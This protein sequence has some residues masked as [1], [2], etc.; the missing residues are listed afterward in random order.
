MSPG[1]KLLWLIVIFSLIR[2]A[3][4]LLLEL[5][6]DEAYYWVWSEYLHLSYYDH[7]PMVSYV[8]WLFTLFSDSE[9]FVRMPAIA[10]AAVSSW[11]LYRMTI[12]LYQDEQAGYRAALIANLCLIFAV[13]GFVT[14]PDS[15][16]IPLYLAGLWFFYKAVNEDGG[17]SYRLWGIAGLFI[18]LAMLSKYTAVFFFPGAMVYLLM[19]KD[20][21]K[22]FLRPHLWFAALVAFGCF[23][24]VVVWNSS[25]D[26]VS[27]SFQAGHGLASSGLSVSRLAEFV[28]FQVVVYSVGIFFF[29]VAALWRLVKGCVNLNRAEGFIFAMSAPII[30]FFLVNGLRA[31]M[32]GNWPVLA[33]LPLIIQ[34]AVM[35]PGWKSSDTKRRLW[36]GSIWFAAALLAF[37]HIQ[38]ANPIVPHPQRYEISRRV[39]GWEL[40]ASKLDSAAKGANATFTLNNRHQIAGLMAYYTEGHMESYVL[41]NNRYRYFFLPE[42]ESR[43][44]ENAVYVTEEER[45]MRKSVSKLFERMEEAERFEIRR[46]GE[47]IRKFVIYRCYNYK[48]GLE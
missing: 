24:P 17:G 14:T 40:L 15:P 37:F 32:E 46:K 39:F 2:V 13:G 10:S 28:G 33:F 22:F 3:M 7:P 12:E 48:G 4:S 23:V 35:V 6:M 19:D 18:G 5:S 34:A 16:L 47:L 30:L 38:V 1:R 8:L 29:L 11:L 42:L 31:R 25:H 44:G 27:L 45:D 26:W 43:V 36:K 9:L 21:R 20:G 41:S